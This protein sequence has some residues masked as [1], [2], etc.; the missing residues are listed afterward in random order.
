MEDPPPASTTHHHLSCCLRTPRACRCTPV[1]CTCRLTSPVA[2]A[3]AS[4]ATSSPLCRITLLVIRYTVSALNGRAP[5]GVPSTLPTCTAV[6]SA[7]QNHGFVGIIFF[8][9]NHA[10]S[11]S[12]RDYGAVQVSNA[13]KT[14][15]SDLN[16]K[17]CFM[18]FEHKVIHHPPARRLVVLWTP[19]CWVRQLPKVTANLWVLGQVRK[20][21]N[22]WLSNTTQWQTE[23]I[24]H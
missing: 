18:C 6:V 10:Q 14:G 17:L 2:P 15:N 8:F 11:T 19:L 9:Q 16:S 21:S 3:C 4:H 12:S 22:S 20:R 7:K 13:V 24:S 5:S 1:N 23:I